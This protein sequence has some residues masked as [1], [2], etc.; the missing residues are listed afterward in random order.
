MGA[1]ERI[2]AELEIN[3]HCLTPLTPSNGRSGLSAYYYYLFIYIIYLNIRLLRRNRLENVQ[4]HAKTTRNAYLTAASGL[5]LINNMFID[6]YFIY[7]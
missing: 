6:M 1:W 5:K 4:S 7:K 3:R 2:A